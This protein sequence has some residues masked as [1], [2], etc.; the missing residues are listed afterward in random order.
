[1]TF[2]PWTTPELTSIGRLPM[3]SVP[4]LDRRELDGRWRF[5][6]LHTPEEELGSSWSEA[7]VPGVW[8]MQDT[9]DK[10]HYT[11]VQMPFAGTPPHVPE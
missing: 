1:V 9:F 3:H 6:L 8:T 2:R 7:A 10:P 4:H 5:Q 11:N